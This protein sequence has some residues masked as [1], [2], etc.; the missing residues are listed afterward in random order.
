MILIISVCFFFSSNFSI[1][2]KIGITTDTSYPQPKTDSNDDKI[3]SELAL[4]FYVSIIICIGLF[5][6]PFFNKE[7][8]QPILLC[9]C[10]LLLSQVFF[11]VCCCLN[12]NFVVC[13]V[14]IMSVIIEQNFYFV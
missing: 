3:A 6:H 5:L 4:Q 9:Y 7:N 13:A 14:I 10:R 8:Y 11:N 2:G 1:E 12:Y